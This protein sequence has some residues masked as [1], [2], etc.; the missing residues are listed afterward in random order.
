M[1]FNNRFINIILICLWSSLIYG[2]SLFVDFKSEKLDKIFDLAKDTNKPVFIYVYSDWSSSTKMLKRK[3]FVNQPVVHYF[4]EHFINY[5]LNIDD[6]EKEKFFLTLDQTITTLPTFLFYTPDGKLMHKHLGIEDSQE[7]MQLGQIAIDETKN[8]GGLENQYNSGIRN[9]DLVEKLAEAYLNAGIDK[10]ETI[11]QEYL[12]TIENWTSERT[13]RMIFTYGKPT[14][15]SD[16]MKYLINNKALFS[17]YLNKRSIEQKINYALQHD[18]QYFEVNVQNKSSLLDHVRKYYTDEKSAEISAEKI[19]L[20]SFFR[21]KKLEDKD[22]L[23]S[24]ITEKLKDSDNYTSTFY[25][26]LAWEIMLL[27]ENDQQLLT[28]CLNWTNKALDRE[29]AFYI[30]DTKANILYRMGR[31]EEALNSINTAFNYKSPTKL[32][33]K[34]AKQLQTL[35]RSKLLEKYQN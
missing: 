30:Y 10:Y 29:K 31:L 6:L 34:L 15:K 14:I 28:Q 35:I 9:V 7:F 20:T 19:L 24:I 2:Q 17:K 23:L 25:N 3:V 1:F 5:R 33:L 32:E 8:L 22:K 26:N 21:S 18:L 27:A 16:L 11:V 13:L 12:S 4:N